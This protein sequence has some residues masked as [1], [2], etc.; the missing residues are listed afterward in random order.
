MRVIEPLTS[1]KLQVERDVV[2]LLLTDG[3]EVYVLADRLAHKAAWVHSIHHNLSWHL[4]ASSV[5]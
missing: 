1:R 4:T 2:Q 3:A 5:L